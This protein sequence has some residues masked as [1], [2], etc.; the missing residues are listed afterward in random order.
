MKSVRIIT[1]KK[2]LYKKLNKLNF[3][4]EVSLEGNETKYI[5]KIIKN[6]NFSG[7]NIVKEN[8]NGKVIL[9]K[10]NPI[11]LNVFFKNK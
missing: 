7:I 1:S 3:N 9:K 11:N 5:E 10:V 8:R 6:I 2:S 4:K